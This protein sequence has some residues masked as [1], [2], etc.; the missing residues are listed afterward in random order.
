MSALSIYP[1]QYA[2]SVAAVRDFAT[3]QNALNDLGVRFER[4]QADFEF[5]ATAD[6]D[7][8]LNAYKNQVELLKNEYGFQSVDVI[9]VKPDHPQQEQLRQKFLAEHVH[10]D[11]EVRFFV[12]GQGLFYLH[13]GNQV[14]IV[15]CE[16]GDLI[17]VP[18]NT[19]HWFDMGSQP[20]FKCIRLFT[21]PDGWQAEF[22]DSQMAEKFPS[23]DEYQ[24]SL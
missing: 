20:D 15:L 7:T 9:N 4:W 1:E 2:E 12:E 5:T 10:A 11:F 8:V 14:Y 3:I 19:K 18:A 6:A 21:T 16:Q 22:T 17:S 13:V 24:A 23:L